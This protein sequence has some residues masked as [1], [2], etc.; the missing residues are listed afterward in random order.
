[1]GMFDTR[2][3]RRYRHIYI[4]ANPHK[5]YEAAVREKFREQV[6]NLRQRASNQRLKPIR[7]TFLLLFL[8]AL[9]CLWLALGGNAG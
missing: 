2:K 9:L 5:D 4:Y 8:A 6:E 7:I 3:P 1:M